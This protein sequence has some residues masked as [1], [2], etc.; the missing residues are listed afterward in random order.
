MASTLPIPVFASC[1]S[2]GRW[3]FIFHVSPLSLGVALFQSRR[4]LTDQRL[5]IFYPDSNTTV[6]PKRVSIPTMTSRSNTYVYKL[7]VPSSH[8]APPTQWSLTLRGPVCCSK[9]PFAKDQR[10]WYSIR[11]SWLTH[12]RR[13]QV[14]IDATEQTISSYVSTR[15]PASVNYCSVT[16]PYSA[17]SDHL[18]LFSVALALNPAIILV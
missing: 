6:R 14:N 5:S 9:K 4:N 11:R 17:A 3:G 12:G 8:C 18:G 15:E 7:H 10:V 2:N 13:Y 16:S 1:L